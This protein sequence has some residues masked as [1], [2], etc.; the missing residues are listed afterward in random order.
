MGKF[1][2][3]VS[4]DWRTIPFGGDCPGGLADRVFAGSKLDG[5]AFAFVSDF[6]HLIQDPGIQGSTVL[7]LQSL[8]SLLG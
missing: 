1:Y 5:Q 6:V 2:C 4:I 7:G 3:L 8:P